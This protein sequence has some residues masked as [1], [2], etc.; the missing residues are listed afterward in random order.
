MLHRTEPRTE[1]ISNQSSWLFI[2]RRE[3]CYSSD[4]EK[5]T[6]GLNS[7]KTPHHILHPVAN[8]VSGLAARLSLA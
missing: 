5:R 7:I 4:K 1:T 8:A 6:N 3:V 2:A